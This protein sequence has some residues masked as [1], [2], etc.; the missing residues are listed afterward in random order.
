M[1]RSQRARLAEG[2]L[3]E[4]VA[5]YVAAM[6]CNLR[7]GWWQGLFCALWWTGR[8]HGW[9]LRLSSSQAWTSCSQILPPSTPPAERD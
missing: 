8:R 4:C 7:V 6:L 1:P 9:L 5:H 3:E 2:L